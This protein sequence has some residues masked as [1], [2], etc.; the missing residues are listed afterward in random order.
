MPHSWSIQELRTEPLEAQF[1]R[2]VEEFNCGLFFECHDT[3]ED[4]WIHYRQADRRFYQ[5][6]IQMAVGCYHFGM[7]NYA[8]ARNL[9]GKGREKLRDYEPMH[10]GLDVA[11]LLREIAPLQESAA[12]AAAGD[13]APS[14][15]L[16]FPRIHVSM[17]G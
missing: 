13:G 11:R 15:D 3:I 2:G 4:L 5:G 16:T 1:L 9:W 17:P 12:R 14:P 10:R 6:V 7:G 8:G